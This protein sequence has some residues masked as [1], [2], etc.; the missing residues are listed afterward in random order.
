M[1]HTVY[2][3]IPSRR[4]VPAKVRAFIEFARSLLVE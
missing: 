1:C 3:V 4:N 2:A